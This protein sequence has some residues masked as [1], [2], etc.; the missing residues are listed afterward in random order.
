MLLQSPFIFFFSK[1]S[2]F[3]CTVLSKVQRHFLYV[4]TFVTKMLA[5]K[6]IQNIQNY[7]LPLFV[8]KIL[9]F[10]TQLLHVTSAW[11]VLLRLEFSCVWLLV[12]TQMPQNKAN[13][14][15]HEEFTQV[16]TFQPLF[17]TCSLVF[18]FTLIPKI[19]LSGRDKNLHCAYWLKPALSSLNAKT[20]AVIIFSD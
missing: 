4:R 20:G 16:I 8:L 9:R 19:R 2:L 6:E 17:S 5:H 12:L 1:K 14:T 10:P 15:I 18:P 11:L 3:S 13:C 7:P